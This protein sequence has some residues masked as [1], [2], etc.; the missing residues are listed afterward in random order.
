MSETQARRPATVADVAR[1][2]KVSKAQAARALGGYGSVSESVRAKVLA[3][4]DQLHYRPNA[5]ARSM[6][7]GRSQTI[8]V[9]IGDVEN[10]FFG[11]ATRGLSDSL[12]DHGYDVVLA[13]TGERVDVEQDAVR[14]MLDKRVDGL[15]ISPASS[16]ATE[17]LSG[18]LDSGRPLVMLDRTID[19]LEVDSVVVNLHGLARQATSELVSMGHRRIG[20]I[21]SVAAPDTGYSPELVLTNSSVADRLAGIIDACHGAGITVDPAWI[22]LNA[23]TPH[24]IGQAVE[25]MLSGPDSPTALIASDSMVGLEILTTLRRLGRRVPQDASFLMFDD[26][27]W[28]SLVSPPISVI[29]QPA[30]DMGVLAAESLL[31]RLSAQRTA[32]VR[33]VLEGRVIH[34]D[35]VSAPA[36]RPPGNG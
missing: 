31:E 12:R 7:T 23:G 3:A 19:T 28:S 10:P 17:H 9:V 21:S 16:V 29:S 20:F 34:R 11:L 6:N 24:A 14:V 8:G 18:F 15:V 2:A 5:L 25:D 32:P 4:A 27:P 1:A 22:R 30:Y 36:V 13:N 35:S 33:H 26:M